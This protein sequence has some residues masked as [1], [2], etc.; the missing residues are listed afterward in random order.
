MRSMNMAARRIASPLNTETIKELRAGDEVLL[1]GVI[2]TARDAAH[3]RIMELLA[4][5]KALPFDIR[6]QTV[7]YAGPCPAP[8]GRAIG[9]V[10]PTTSARM[11]VYAPRLIAQGLRVMIGKGNR[12]PQVIDALR[13]HGGVYFAAV[14]GAGALLSLAVERAELAA[15]ADL[16]PE[17]VYK[18]TVCDMPLVTAIDSRGGTIY[19]EF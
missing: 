8:P 9:S 10:G 1:S 13:E 14:G 15:F 3:K 17:A 7:Y 12:G 4:A 5:G 19:K 6:N 2:Y 16:G 11:D 18:L